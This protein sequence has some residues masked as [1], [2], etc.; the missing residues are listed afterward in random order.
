VAA[1]GG[2]PDPGIAAVEPRPAYVPLGSRATRAKV[3]LVVAGVVDVAAALS[4]LQLLRLADEAQQIGAFTII[5]L[6]AAEN[7]HALIETVQLGAYVL[8]GIVFIAWFHRAYANLLAVGVDRLRHRTGWA[9]GAWFIP[10]VSLVWPKRIA[11]EIWRGSN[12]DTD[13]GESKV[14]SLYG[15][16]WRTFIVGGILVGVGANLWGGAGT[17]Q[18]L[19][20]AAG[21]QL[22]GNL[23]G[24][25]SGILAF[26][27]VDR[28]SDRQNVR[29]T[30]LDVLRAAPSA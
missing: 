1:A 14:P 25:A 19:E 18:Q 7:R 17:P 8:A 30:R 12:P 3:L 2:E 22:I 15:A 27:V 23:L 29:A 28:T 20:V 24:V 21:L 26:I 5:D 11:D 6:E 16:W 10:I 4:S 13:A 9:I